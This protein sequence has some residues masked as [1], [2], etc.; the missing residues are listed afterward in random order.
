MSITVGRLRRAQLLVMLRA[1]HR[2]MYT[3]FFDKVQN[4]VSYDT[5]PVEFSETGKFESRRSSRINFLNSVQHD[6]GRR[7]QLTVTRFGSARVTTSYVLR[8]GG[9]SQSLVAC[10]RKNGLSSCHPFGDC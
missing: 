9:D 8:C 4:F 2:Q 1:R 3:F 7:A 6:F 10:P 5:R